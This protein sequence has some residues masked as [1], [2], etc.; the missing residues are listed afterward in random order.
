MC[1]EM[2]DEKHYEKHYE[3]CEEGEFL[4]DLFSHKILSMSCLC[5]LQ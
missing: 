4:F 3:M 1:D 5:Y 2:C